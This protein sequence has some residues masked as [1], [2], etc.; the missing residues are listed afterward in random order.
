M[1]TSSSVFEGCGVGF[2]D[3][4]FRSFWFIEFIIFLNSSNL[5]AGI[6]NPFFVGPV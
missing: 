4:L 5:L 1:P 6:L 2:C 3:W